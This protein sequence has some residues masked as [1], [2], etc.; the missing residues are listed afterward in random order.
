MN[1]SLNRILFDKSLF[2]PKNEF[3]ETKSP[4][5][6]S[7][8]RLQFLLFIFESLSS[9]YH[10]HFLKTAVWVIASCTACITTSFSHAQTKS[11]AVVPFNPIFQIV[12]FTLA[13]QFHS[14]T[15][16]NL[17]NVGLSVKRRIIRPNLYNIDKTRFSD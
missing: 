16:I 7:T 1:S 15:P 10:V 12:D 6:L 3:G 4:K 8:N 14:L 5:E 11:F 17:L 2:K 13:N 9:A